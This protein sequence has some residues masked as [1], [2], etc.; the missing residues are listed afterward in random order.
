MQKVIFFNEIQ[1]LGAFEI[2]DYESAH[3]IHNSKRKI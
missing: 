1:Y 2:A 3:K